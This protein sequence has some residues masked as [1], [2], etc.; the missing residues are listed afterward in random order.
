M[1]EFRFLAEQL[2]ETWG[3]LDTVWE[4]TQQV[5]NDPVAREFQERYWE[6]MVSEVRSFHYKMEELARTIAQALRSVK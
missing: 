1:N 4:R 3:R 2:R 6:P 5:W